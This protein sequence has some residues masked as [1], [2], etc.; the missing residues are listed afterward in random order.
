V[1]AYLANPQLYHRKIQH[2]FLNPSY[3]S[4]QANADPTFPSYYQAARI[5]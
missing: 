1:I 5:F 3:P 4:N 2:I